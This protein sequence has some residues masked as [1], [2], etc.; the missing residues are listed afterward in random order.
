MLKLLG[1]EPIAI[2]CESGP[3]ERNRRPAGFEESEVEQTVAQRFAKQA[4]AHGDR[5]AIRTRTESWTYAELTRRVTG[6]ARSVLAARGGSSE[7]VAVL[8]DKTPLAYAMLLGVL[9]A[10]KFYVPLNPRCPDARNAFLLE[11]SGARVILADARN[12]AGA[13]SL[14]SPGVEVIDCENLDAGTEIHVAVD[15]TPDDPVYI[16]Y[17]SGTAG[18]PKGVLESHRNLLNN[19]RNYT[20]EYHL[21]PGDRMLCLGSHVY[22]GSLKDIYGALLNGAALYPVDLERDGLTGLADWMT[23]ERV[24]VYDSVPTVYRHFV[25]TLTGREDLSA[26]RIVRL[27]GEPLTHRDVEL[28]RRHFPRE[29]VFV[30]GF[31]STETGTSCTFAVAHDTPL[32][33]RQVPIGRPPEGTTVLVLGDDGRPLPA[34]EV[35][36]LAVRSEFLAI[37][38]WKRPDLT[39]RAFRTDLRGI[40]GR[41]YLTGDLGYAAAD[42]C[43][44][45]VG[46]RDSQVKVRGHRVETAEVEAE[47]LAYPGVRQAAVVVRSDRGLDRYLVG[48]LVP[49]DGARPPDLT[50]LRRS[51]RSRLPDHAVPSALVPVLSFPVTANGKLDVE[52]FPA[53]EWP[54]TVGA[55]GGPRNPTE[56][57]LA[58]IWQDVLGLPRVGVADDFFSLGGT[59]LAAAHLMVRVRE[60]FGVELPLTALLEAGTIERLAARVASAGARGGE[61]APSL[62]PIQP[63]GQRPPLFLVHGLGGEVLTYN[64]LARHLGPD[65]PVYGFR[66]RCPRAGEE[67]DFTIESMAAAY[68]AELLRFRA[69]GPYLLGGCSSGGLLAFEMARQL[70]ALDH[71]VAAVLVIDHRRPGRPPEVP[72]TLSNLARA[73][74][75]FPR[76]V[77]T[78]LLGNRPTVMWARHWG[79]IGT[80]RRRLIGAAPDVSDSVDLSRFPDA[81]RALCRAIFRAVRNYASGPYRGRVWLFK[82][83]SQPLRPGI[84]HRRDMGW[85]EIETGGLAISEV[86][87]NHETVLAEPNVQ[88]VAAKIRQVLSEV[89]GA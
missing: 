39:A 15:A 47:M 19:I 61:S 78:D 26:V 64:L 20:T 65:Q 52:G 84:W 7:P 63:C 70:V 72:W 35:G 79:R 89:V 31:G 25:A 22:S 58:G 62:V 45:G 40:D 56:T 27:G 80:L 14:A 57:R 38:Y 41:V 51:L 88:Q 60:E 3:D 24:T 13:R 8:A 71:E 85:G 10:G 69:T 36:Q 42:G 86:P 73:A 53:P 2:P 81:I 44:F 48:Y 49:A 5:L 55:G 82:A 4:A 37:G 11:D 68:V 66:A 32:R 30:N 28:F 74:R 75:N 33:H 6:I 9:A 12:S 67:P 29:S 76:W 34:G 18:R 46:R 1:D 16:L 23:A 21:T 43:L 17:T 83:R 87:G 54:D 50:A 59:S 77:R